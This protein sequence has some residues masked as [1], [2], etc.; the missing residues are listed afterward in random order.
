VTERRRKRDFYQMDRVL[1]L[2]GDEAPVA[3]RLVLGKGLSHGFI[4]HISDI[5]SE[6]C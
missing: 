6:T 4:G 3:M 5:T 1:R 2:M